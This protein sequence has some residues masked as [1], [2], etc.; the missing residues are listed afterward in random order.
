M[1]PQEAQ[2]LKIGTKVRMTYRPITSQP[3]TITKEVVVRRVVQQTFSPF[4]WQV[5]VAEPGKR[6]QS[7]HG[8][9]SIEAVE[10]C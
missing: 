2:Q 8:I 1:T 5:W 3:G 10:R 7:I 6:R 4:S 9:G